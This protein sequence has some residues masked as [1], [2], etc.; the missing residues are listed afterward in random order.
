MTTSTFRQIG[1]QY[2]EQRSGKNS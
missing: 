1:W 2:G